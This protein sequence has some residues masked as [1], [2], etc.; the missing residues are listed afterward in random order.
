MMCS[1][2]P[3]IGGFS[4]IF[5]CHFLFLKGI[6]QRYSHLNSPILR[7]FQRGASRQ[8]PPQPWSC[9]WWWPA[10][11]DGDHQVAVA[12]CT[13]FLDQPTFYNF[14]IICII[15]FYIDFGT[16]HLAE[17]VPYMD[18]TWFNI[19][20]PAWNRCKK[21]TTSNVSGVPSLRHW[22]HVSERRKN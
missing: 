5:H 1:S 19:I 18:W 11:F 15:L 10:V 21:I 8:G 9:Q 22:T 6:S 16:K 4:W 14:Y 2:E 20:S 3:P 13:R 17:W 7:D 12:W